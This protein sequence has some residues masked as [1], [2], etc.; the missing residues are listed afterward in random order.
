MVAFAALNAPGE[1]TAWQGPIVSGWLAGT[2]IILAHIGTATLL[3]A[4]GV[5][6][7]AGDGQGTAVLL[8][9]PGA[10][11]LAGDGTGTA[12][13]APSLADAAVAR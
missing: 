10:A 13:L 9:A 3:Q 11:A 1:L 4:A 5:A 6:V 7:L 2:A 8:Q 12:R